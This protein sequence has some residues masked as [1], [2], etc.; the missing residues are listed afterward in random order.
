MKQTI[1]WCSILVVMFALVLSGPL[2]RAQ[3][4]SGTAKP[5]PGPGLGL[6]A[7]MFIYPG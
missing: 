2:A 3:Q 5:K 4:P 1:Q 7:E 6:A